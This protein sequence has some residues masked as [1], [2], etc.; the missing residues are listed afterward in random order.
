M[1]YMYIIHKPIVT[2]RGLSLGVFI[3]YI[4]CMPCCFYSNAG[5]SRSS[6][7]ALAYVLHKEKISL[8][9]ALKKL[10]KTRPS[11]EPSGNFMKQLRELEKSL[12][13]AHTL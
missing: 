2:V 8:D 3:H 10:R 1:M 11:V 12:G 13:L 5:R 4:V 9:T 7:I 6:S